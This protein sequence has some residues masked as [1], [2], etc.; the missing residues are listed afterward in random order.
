MYVS[1]KNVLHSVGSII[2]IISIFNH[3][4]Y[5]LHDD[6]L[7]K[8]LFFIIADNCVP[9]ERKVASPRQANSSEGPVFLQYFQLPSQPISF[10]TVSVVIILVTKLA[11]GNTKQICFLFGFVSISCPLVFIKVTL[12]CIISL[13]IRFQIYFRTALLKKI[14]PE[15]LQCIWSLGYIGIELSELIDLWILFF[16]IATSD[17]EKLVCMLLSVRAI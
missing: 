4:H 3:H 8:A 17:D 10:H 15:T 14:Q 5:F 16:S 12:F 6:T 2:S 9:P 7:G 13:F 11:N 1:S